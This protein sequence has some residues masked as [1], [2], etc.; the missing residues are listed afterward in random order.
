MEADS[1]RPGLLDRWR[2]YLRARRT[3]G[4]RDCNDIPKSPAA[5]TI[6]GDESPYQVM[7]NGIKVLL[8]GYH[9]RW[10]V[11]VI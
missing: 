4:C 3:I 2:I 7:H 8:G 6:A 5:G 1:P 10:M 11:E 9:G